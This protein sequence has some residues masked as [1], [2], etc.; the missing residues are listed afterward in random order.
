[1]IS[2]RPLAQNEKRKSKDDACRDDGAELGKHR[3][4]AAGSKFRGLAPC[5]RTKII[6]V[7]LHVQLAAI[8]CARTWGRRCEKIIAPKTNAPFVI[9]AKSGPAAISIGAQCSRASLG[10][11]HPRPGRAHVTPARRPG[12]PLF[13]RGFRDCA[14]A[15]IRPCREVND[16]DIPSFARTIGTRSRRLSS[17]IGLDR[18][19]PMRLVAAPEGCA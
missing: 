10:K 18:S 6:H 8:A 9:V 7:G 13:R 15:R 3:P 12:S 11:E 14:V 5:S 19:L 16:V 17:F 4:D 1:M 2:N